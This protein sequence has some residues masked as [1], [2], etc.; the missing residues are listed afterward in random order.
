M[1]NILSNTL[2]H[3]KTKKKINRH[4]T[5]VFILHICTH[6]HEFWGG[7]S[8]PVTSLAGWLFSAT[9]D[10]FTCYFSPSG[11]LVNLC[12]C[13]FLRN[14]VIYLPIHLFPF[15]IIYCLETGYLKLAFTHTHTHTHTHSTCMCACTYTHTHA[16]VRTHT[17]MHARTHIH[18]HSHSPAWG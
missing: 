5:K 1:I 16:H 17:H 13:S 9:H 18:P 12:T 7:M 10:F 11:L 4:G 14:L 15:I 6:I 8:Y 3:L 2:G